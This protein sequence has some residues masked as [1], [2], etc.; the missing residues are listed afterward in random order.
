MKCVKHKQD[1]TEKKENDSWQV[2]FQQK[3]NSS[4]DI[5]KIMLK[6]FSSFLEPDRFKQKD[7][8]AKKKRR[9]RKKLENA[10]KGSN[11]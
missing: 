2:T 6:R 9:K 8:E 5:G 4:V 10:Y 3:Q 1:D 7:K 11:V